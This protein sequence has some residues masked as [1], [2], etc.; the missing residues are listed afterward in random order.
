MPLAA[1]ISPKNP[2]SQNPISQK[3]PFP[4]MTPWGHMSIDHLAPGGIIFNIPR[5]FPFLTIPQEMKIFH[6]PAFCMVQKGF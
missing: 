2:F 6:Q 3:I 4:Y 5:L 1:S